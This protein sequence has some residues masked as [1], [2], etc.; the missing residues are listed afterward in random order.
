MNKTL[1]DDDDHTTP[2]SDHKIPWSYIKMTFYIIIYINTL[3]QNFSVRW[4][5]TL[6]KV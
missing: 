5:T 3:C 4:Y 1:T 6:Y 2:L